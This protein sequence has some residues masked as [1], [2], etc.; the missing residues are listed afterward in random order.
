MNA[1]QAMKAIV[2]ASIISSCGI[3]PAAILSP[4]DI[5]VSSLGE[6]FVDG[7]SAIF[8]VDPETGDRTIVTGP[9]VGSGPEFNPAGAAVAS[10]YDV[11]FT[12]NVSDTASVFHLDVVT[13]NRQV[14]ASTTI[15]TGP[16]IQLPFDVIVRGDGKLVVADA[17]GNALVL[18]DP[19]TLERSILS[20]SGVGLGPDFNGP[21]GMTLDA[22]GDIFVTVA[23]SPTST[24]FKVDPLTGNREIVSS[25]D[26]GSGPGTD[27]W[28]DVALDLAG[29]ALVT[30]L[31][32]PS[33]IRGVIDIN[34]DTGDRD[35]L[36]ASGIG[37]GPVLFEPWSIG[38]ES[39]GHILVTNAVANDALIRIDPASGDRTI[40]S[41]FGVGSGPDLLTPLYLDIVPVPEPSS[42]ILFIS[43]VL[44]MLVARSQRVVSVDKGLLRQ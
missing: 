2:F 10:V 23:T 12:D 17:G 32:G 38:V 1:K 43:G 25:S 35:I 16:V 34:L 36:S 29:H 22:N 19:A 42:V 3:S 8:K 41:G 39:D 27:L 33:P 6:L 21:V 9:G 14:I 44:L 4:G 26:M 37:A 15:G 24:L 11:Y 30:N 13:G 28:S 31:D 18:V 5:V 7:D 40:V 20:G